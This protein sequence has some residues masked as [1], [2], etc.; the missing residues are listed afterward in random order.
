MAK[1][2]VQYTHE[3]L[4][5]RA[6]ILDTVRSHVKNTRQS[7]CGFVELAITEKINREGI[8]TLDRQNE[9]PLKIEKK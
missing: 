3:S 2:K 7:M 8:P 9:W 1:Q 5:V 6:E 4:R